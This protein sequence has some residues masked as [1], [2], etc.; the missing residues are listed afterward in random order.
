ML[1]DLDKQINSEY[2]RI[3][4]LK[5]IQE[6][7]EHLNKTLNECIEIVSSSVGNTHTQERLIRMK[8]ENDVSYSRIN[9]DINQTME[10]SNT[11]INN[12]KL[13]KK[14]L[15]EEKQKEKREES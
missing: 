13:E 3:K 2:D 15:E 9:N 11:R 10:K 7:V 6:E 8:E 14:A 5:G 1:E 12:L 4:Q